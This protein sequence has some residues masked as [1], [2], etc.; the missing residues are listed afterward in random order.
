MKFIIRAAATG[1]A[2]L[3]L[4][5]CADIASFAATAASNVSSQTPAQVSTLTNAITAADLATKAVD[6]YVNA[7][8]PSKA[9]LV[10]LNALNEGLHTALTGLETDQAAGKSLVFASFNEA[11]A[12]F[13]AYATAKGVSH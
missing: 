2:L 1:I 9:V 6:I 5:G 8:S 7:A 10:E 13:N 11:L 3:M 12:A 4:S